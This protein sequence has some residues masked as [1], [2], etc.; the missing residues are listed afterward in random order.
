MSDEVDNFLAHF[1]VKGMKW[2]KRKGENSSVTAGAS[3]AQAPK[4]LSKKEVRQINRDGQNDHDKARVQKVFDES[5]KKGEKVLVSTMMQGDYA[6]TIMTGKQF[7]EHA[8]T[9]GA[10][11]ARSTDIYAERRSGQ[12]ELRDNS[13]SEYQKVKR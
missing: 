8:M 2:G 13:N 7:V 3:L 11:N 6:K 9:G 12:Y 1:G 10:V 4:R 5:Y